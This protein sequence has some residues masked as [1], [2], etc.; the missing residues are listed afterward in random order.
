MEH[1]KLEAYKSSR[2]K[3]IKQISIGA[4]AI[5]LGLS[6]P[7]LNSRNLAK[8]DSKKMGIALVGL[9]NYSTRVLAPAL[10]ETNECYLACI[11][12]GTPSKANKWSSQYDIPK[13]NIYNYDTFDEIAKNEDVD[14]VYVVL[15]NSMHAEYTI[16]AAKAGKHVICEKPMALNV[17]ECQSMIDACKE[18]NV[19]LSIGYRMHFERNT[20]EVIKMEREKKFGN[21]LMLNAGAGFYMKNTDVWRTK[22]AMG[23][24]AMQDIGIYALNAARYITGEEPIS[25]TAQAYNSRPNQLT[26]I[27]ET[28]TF[29]LLFP[30]GIIANCIGSF[31]M[32]ITDL[33]AQ[34]SDGWFELNPFWTYKGIKGNSSKGPIQFPNVNQQAVQMDEMSVSFRDNKPLLVTGMEGLRDVKIIN[35]IDESIKTKNKV[36]L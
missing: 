36:N 15:P 27:D 25:V 7:L 33:Y 22:K 13:K 28:V 29:Q 14:I 10:Q 34:T 23:G 32:F 24:G 21:L 3:F 4:G 8:N 2:R 19:G 35:A 16:R 11:V 12:T 1:S 6:S 31:G 17:E 9:G 5:S 20:Q 30:G 18:N 26:E